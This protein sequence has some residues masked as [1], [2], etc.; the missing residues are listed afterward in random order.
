M[1]T[2]RFGMASIIILLAPACTESPS[3]DIGPLRPGEG[4]VVNLDSPGIDGDTGWWPAVTFDSHDVP[5]ISY[6]D[7]EH[8]DLRY[9]TKAQGRWKLSTIVSEGNVGKYSSVAVD[10]RGRVGIVFYD[11][12]TQWLRFA[13]NNPVPKTSPQKKG[14]GAPIVSPTP[15]KTERIAWGRELGF[16]AE[17][18]FDAHNEAHVFY[19]VPSGRLAHAHR[20][21]EAKWKK[22]VV[23]VVKGSFTVRI[24]PKLRS[25]GFWMS[26]VDWNFLNTRLYLASPAKA[27]AR[28]PL[29]EVGRTLS[30]AVRALKLPPTR[31]NRDLVST[32]KSPG[33]RS[34]LFFS[35]KGDPIIMYTTSLNA[36]LRLAQRK[37]IK[38]AKELGPFQE[39]SRYE[40][41]WQ[42]RLILTNVGNF[43]ASQQKDGTFTIA[44]EDI[45]GSKIGDGLIRY[46]RLKGHQLSRHVFDAEGPSGQYLDMATNSRGETVIA[47]YARDT[48]GLRLY[49]ETPS[50]AP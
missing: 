25:D 11:Q 23:A 2:P 35:K 3:V 31:F 42:D 24:D 10:A 29:A 9:A 12:D 46:A 38:N 14:V 16:A 7:A 32:E 22:E 21:G 13:Y 28:I 36:H 26:Y 17:L 41:L 6:C 40:E 47:Y 39:D 30:K 37:T 33:W 34:Q 4:H 27:E 15:W 1:K 20:I 8:G 19:Y 5:H 49:D 45:E 48:R 50:K 18:R 44:Y 43:A